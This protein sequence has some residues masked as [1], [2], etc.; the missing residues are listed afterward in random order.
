MDNNGFIS[1]DE[2]G[3]W[4]YGKRSLGDFDDN[5][6]GMLDHYEFL[7]WYDHIYYLVWGNIQ[8]A[9]DEMIESRIKRVV[10]SNCLKRVFKTFCRAYIRETKINSP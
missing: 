6:D 8:S 7:S 5:G 3:M 9:D 10:T 1:E 4:N 2:F